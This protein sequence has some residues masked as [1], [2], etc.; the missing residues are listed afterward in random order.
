MPNRKDPLLWVYPLKKRVLF[1]EYPLYLHH[2]E[3]WIL[4]RG[5]S[6]PHQRL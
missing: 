6:F 5:I 1:I 4:Y 2:I 3:K